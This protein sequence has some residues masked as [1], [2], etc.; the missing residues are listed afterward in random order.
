MPV[1]WLL[2]LLA[3]GAHADEIATIS[4][5]RNF[6]AC[7]LARIGAHSVKNHESCQEGGK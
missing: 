4:D 2:A 6:R 1:R 3:V 7:S 5:G